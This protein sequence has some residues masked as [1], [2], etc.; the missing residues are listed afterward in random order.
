MKHSGVPGFQVQLHA[1]NDAPL[2]PCRSHRSDNKATPQ[3]ATI[4]PRDG[5]ILV[6]TEVAR[7]MVFADK[8]VLFVGKWVAPPAAAADGA[9][10]P[11]GFKLCCEVR[12]LLCDGSCMWQ[13]NLQRLPPGSNLPGCTYGHAALRG[14]RNPASHNCHVPQLPCATTAMCLNCHVPRHLKP[15]TTASHATHHSITCNTPLHTQHST[16]P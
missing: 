9:A 8:A 2:L 5:V 1:S 4:A 15:H 14:P 16:R 3:R 12:L 10:E 6:R 11:A 7:A 13:C